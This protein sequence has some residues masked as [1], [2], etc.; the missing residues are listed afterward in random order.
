MVN[1]WIKIW[2]N[3][4][5]QNVPYNWW[6]CLQKCIHS[7]SSHNVCVWA[8]N[9]LHFRKTSSS[10]SVRHSGSVGIHNQPY[11]IPLVLNWQGHT[12]LILTVDIEITFDV[13]AKLLDSD[14]RVNHHV[15]RP[16]DHLPWDRDQHFMR[17][18]PTTTRPR[19]RT[20]IWFRDHVGLET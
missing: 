7:C 10:S 11:H 14:L 9:S 20:K 5:Q 17:P 13:L 1:V 16:R 15:K 6:V 12:A 8:L 4:H 2:K 18:G 3:Q 19:P